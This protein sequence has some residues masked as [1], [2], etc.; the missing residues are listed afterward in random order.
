M[1][2]RLL[3]LKN[4]PNI[5]WHTKRSSHLS[6]LHLRGSEV[7][8]CSLWAQSPGYRTISQLEVKDTERW[9]A[10][11][12]D[13]KRPPTTSNGSV[14]KATFRRQHP[15]NFFRQGE[16]HY[17]LSHTHSCAKKHMHIE[18]YTCTQSCTYKTCAHT[19]TFEKLNCTW[20]LYQF[21]FYFIAFCTDIHKYSYFPNIIVSCTSNINLSF[22]VVTFRAICGESW[23]LL[24]KELQDRISLPAQ[25]SMKDHSQLSGHEPSIL[26]FFL[27]LLS[28]PPPPPPCNCSIKRVKIKMGGSTKWL[29]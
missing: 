18:T 2:S 1:Q 7:L 22:T 17:G 29:F 20:N 26:Q 11:G 9:C 23:A 5:A 4:W 12:K 25:N 21:F 27:K 13:E 6:S 16:A 24:S 14:S 3:M 8:R 15:G 10:P 28:L 19:H